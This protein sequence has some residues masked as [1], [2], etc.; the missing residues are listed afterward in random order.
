MCEQLGLLRFILETLVIID[1]G[2][3]RYFSMKGR[4]WFDVE[5]MD[6]WMSWRKSG[7]PLSHWVLI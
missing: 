4:V 5:E 3:F 6:Q 2:T 7:F 1:I